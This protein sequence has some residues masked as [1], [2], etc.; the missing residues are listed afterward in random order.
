MLLKPGMTANLDIF[1]NRLS[2]VIYIPLQAVV[3]HHGQ[4]SVTVVEANG[5]KKNVIVTLGARNDTD[6]QVLHGLKAGQKVVVHLGNAM[7]MWTPHH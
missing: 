1:T 3:I 7:S 2:N 6:W 5:I 4:D